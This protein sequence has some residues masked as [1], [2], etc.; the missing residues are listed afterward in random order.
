MLSKKTADMV[1]LLLEMM[2]NSSF[3]FKE[4]ADDDVN[5]EDDGSR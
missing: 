2:G 5:S 1:L 4:E 3:G